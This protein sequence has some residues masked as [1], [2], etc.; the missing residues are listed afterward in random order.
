[1][2]RSLLIFPPQTYQQEV[3]KGMKQITILALGL[4]TLGIMAASARAQ[5][6]PVAMPDPNPP[7]PPITT[8]NPPPPV[9][10]FNPPPPPH[11]GEAECFSPCP[12]EAGC[13]RRG[14]LG[15]LCDRIRCRR[16]CSSCCAPA[17]PRC[18][19]PACAPDCSCAPSCGCAPCTPCCPPKHCGLFS[20]LR[21]RW[22]ERHGCCCGP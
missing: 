12:C 15:R 6:D 16:Q 10:D 3:N 11:A 14:I 13:C 2:K 5:G 19:E 7:P 8:F 1:M 22:A 9:T 17:S 20:R 4:L 21:A 18:S